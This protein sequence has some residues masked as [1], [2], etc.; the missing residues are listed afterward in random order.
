MDLF[1]IYLFG[2]ADTIKGAFG[3]FAIGIAVI[4]FF[5]SLIL[6]DINQK[7]TFLYRK[8]VA[9]IVIILTLIA[10]LIPSSSTI[11]YMVA[12]SLGKQA[13]QSETADKLL[14]LVN[15]KLDEELKET[16]KEIKP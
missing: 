12:Y 9:T 2:Q 10:L 3:A 5:G 15:S 11:A 14:R 16:I 1:V 13:V 4:Y 6:S 7:T 8:T